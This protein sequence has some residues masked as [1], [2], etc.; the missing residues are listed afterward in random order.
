[1][2]TLPDAVM[3]AIL[4]RTDE[5]TVINGRRR[6]LA[7]PGNSSIISAGACACACA[8]RSLQRCLK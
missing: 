6:S 3:C 8:M 5:D 2:N 7:T 1:M 4:A